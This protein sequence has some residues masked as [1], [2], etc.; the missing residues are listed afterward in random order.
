MKVFFI[1]PRFLR[2]PI[3]DFIA[4]NR[5]RWFGKKDTCMMPDKKIGHLFL[6]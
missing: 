5:Y 6:Q 4:K 1:I 3:Y 2:D